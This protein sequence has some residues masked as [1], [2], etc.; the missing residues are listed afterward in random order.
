MGA[1]AEGG[2]HAAG[3][4]Q[5]HKAT[6]HGLLAVAWLLCAVGCSDDQSVTGPTAGADAAANDVHTPDGA[7]V[8]SGPIADTAKSPDTID[9]ADVAADGGF[10]LAPPTPDTKPE[11]QQANECPAPTKVCRVATCEAGHCGEAAA[12]D[13][14]DC[15]DDDACTSLEVCQG[16]VCLPGEVTPCE[17]G[18]GC[19][20]DSCDSNVGCVHKPSTGSCDDADACTVNDVCKAGSCVSGLPLPCGDG[21]PCTEDSCD[22]AK[23]GCV[24]STT[25]KPCDDGNACTLADGCVDGICLP[26]AATNC[27]DLQACTSD[28]CNPQSGCVNTPNVAPCDDGDACTVADKCSAG[29]CKSG[30]PLVCNDGNPCTDDDCKAG[31]GCLSTPNAA[32]CSDSNVCTQDDGC[33]GG[34]CAPGKALPCDDAN[35][36]TTDG[37]DPAQ[38][39]GHVA[40]KLPCDDG[41]ACT[42]A[43]LCLKGACSGG[44]AVDCNDAN[45]CTDDACQLASGCTHT[46]NAAACDDNNVCTEQ[47]ACEQGSCKPGIVPDCDDGNGCTTET[48]DPKQGCKNVAN[49]QA[50]SD[51]DACSSGDVC[52]DGK[53]TAGAQVVCNDGN[54]CTDD[55]CDTIAGCQSKHN[56][57]GCSDGNVCT[58]ADA[59]KGGVCL[60]GAATVCDDANPCTTDSCDPAQGCLSTAN[61]L[62][63]D[64]GSVCTAGDQCAQGA[65][66][67]GK[68]VKCDD[69]NACTADSC[70]LAQGCTAVANSAACDDGN[71][72]TSADACA[73]SACAGKAVVCD[74][75]NACT[76]D[77]C[78]SGKGCQTILPV[79]PCDD[80]SKCTVGDTCAAGKCVG[81]PV[82]CDDANPCTTDSCAADKGCLHPALSDG[83]KCGAAG[84]CLAGKCSLGSDVTPA[85]SCKQILDTLTNPPSAVYWLDPDGVGKGVDKFQTWCDMTADGGG[86]TLIAKIDGASNTFVYNSALWTNA[87]TLNPNKPELDSGQAKLA[88]FSTVPFEELR[89]GMKLGAQ[90]RWVKVQHKSTSLLAALAPGTYRPFD[91]AIGRVAWKGLLNGSSLQPNCNREGFNNT[92]ASSWAAVRIGIIANEQN[93]CG[94]PDSRIGFGGGGNVCGMDANTSVGNGAGCGGDAGNKNLKA[95]FGWILVR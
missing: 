38:G 32:P 1:V 49:T 33:V 84:V 89:L 2:R 74:D 94:T 86:W 66:A 83:S 10:D 85:T 11:C 88:S 78:D 6:P 18:N 67:P 45:P 44:A 80:G 14:I 35:P 24:H 31:S 59:C 77:Y 27:D 54:G 73:A 41:D 65:C 5:M 75:G 92:V 26:G 36:C 95:N 57:A 42:G 69:G 93:N 53:C 48:C 70:D 90:T 71:A 29:A 13:G 51:G 12:L 30:A 91:K 47:D 52:A 40:N 22:S 72:C 79:V 60:P 28:S 68:V 17:D 76:I 7:S 55:A 21:N 25:E 9:A 62:P 46:T 3:R 20:F 81:D 87:A 37:C 50:C 16:G 8:D 64:D 23:T 43:D 34:A 56:V 4:G 15:D 39:C 63:C 82:V 58:T 61:G 19:T